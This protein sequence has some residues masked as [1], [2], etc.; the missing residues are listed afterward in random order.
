MFL[1]DNTAAV[2]LIGG[3]HGHIIY[4]FNN[5]INTYISNLLALV[6]L[7]SS[8]KIATRCK[9]VLGVY[10]TCRRIFWSILHIWILQ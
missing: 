2:N 9:T 1:S 7:K 10:Y 4:S 5:R 8:Q 6:I 3:F